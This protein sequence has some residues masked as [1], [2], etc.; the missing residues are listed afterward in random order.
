MFE[1]G[2][3]PGLIIQIL[4][5]LLGIVVLVSGRRLFWV[6]V[7]VVGFIAGLI[8][9]LN[10]LEIQPIWLAWLAAIGVGIIGAVLAIFLQHIAVGTAGFLLGGYL[11]IWLAQLFKLNTAQWGWII[12]I[13]GGIIGLILAIWLF[14]AALI[15][16]SSLAGAAII[17]S[18][19]NFQPVITTLLFVL[20][21]IV[22][23]VIQS[24]R[25]EQPPA[26]G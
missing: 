6:T 10:L 24:R 5:V 22:G 1:N 11:L 15:G 8:I 26:A 3:S 4:A 7:A 23:I 20:L 13:V 19:T 2:A 18:V 9:A 14:E 12:F 25:L 16:L 17:V 21:V